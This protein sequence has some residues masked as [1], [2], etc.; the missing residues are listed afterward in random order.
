MSSHSKRDKWL[1][2]LESRQRNTVFPDTVQNETRF[3]RN[4]GTGPSKLSTKVGL[5]VLAIFVFAF[6]AM[7]LVATYQAGVIWLFIL[8]MLFFCGTLFGALA[9]ATRKSLRNIERA[10][11]DPKLRRP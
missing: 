1:Q 5:S 11:R 3:W 6:A 9:W 8:G 4:L 7:I 2:D 10:R